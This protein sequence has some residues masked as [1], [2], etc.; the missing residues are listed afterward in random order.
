MPTQHT[1]RKRKRRKTPVQTSGLLWVCDAC[2]DQVH[3]M[4]YVAR[5]LRKER[6][7]R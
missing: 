1:E 5:N 3:S 7:L 6:R 4:K 2:F